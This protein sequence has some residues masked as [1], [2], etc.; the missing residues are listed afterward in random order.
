MT[1][2]YRDARTTDIHYKKGGVKM[3]KIVKRLEFLLCACFVFFQLYTAFFGNL[4]GIS[5]KAVHLG[6]MIS[7]IFLG[8]CISHQSKKFGK[9]LQVFDILFAAFGLFFAVYITS[10][11][12][13]LTADTTLYTPTMRVVGIAIILD[14]GYIGLD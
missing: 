2:L 8:A 6:L 11:A 4:F 14:A 12:R 5:Q 13:A 3:D 7:I 9:I 1:V 10:I